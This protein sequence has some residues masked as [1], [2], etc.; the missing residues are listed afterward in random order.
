M[1]AGSRVV[2]LDKRKILLIH[3]LK[4]G[5]EYYVLPGG[6]IEKDESPEDAAIREVK[7]ETNFDVELGSLLWKFRENVDGESR[8]GYYFL[9]RKFNGKLKLGGPEAEMQSNDNS[10]LLEWFP[11][12]DLDKILFYPKEIGRKIQAK[13]FQMNSKKSSP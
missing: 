6:T 3:R 4:D 5:K 2:I 11:I 7:E 12:A 9:A 1:V 10:Y 8:L 13:L